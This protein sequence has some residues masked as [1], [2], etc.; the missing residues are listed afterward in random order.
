MLSV[1]ADDVRSVPYRAI[2]RVGPT[3]V[4]CLYFIDLLILFYPQAKYSE[5]ASHPFLLIKSRYSNK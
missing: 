1:P 4:Y 2:Y 3:G 5:V